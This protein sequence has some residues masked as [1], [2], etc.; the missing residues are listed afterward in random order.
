MFF[1]KKKLFTFSHQIENLSNLSD[2]QFTAEEYQWIAE[3]EVS[4]LCENK[5]QT[6]AY[7]IKGNFLKLESLSNLT[8][9]L[10][11]QNRH[12]TLISFGSGQCVLEYFLSIYLNQFLA[13][14]ATDFNKFF[15][16]KAQIFF[17]EISPHVFDFQKDSLSKLIEKTGVSFDIGVGFGS[18]YAMDDE[19]FIQFLRSCKANGLKEI[20]DFNPGY[21]C[22]TDILLNHF[23]IEKIKSN[24]LIRRTFGKK[25]KPLKGK[26]HGYARSRASL[27]R[28][29]S[30]S[31][32]QVDQELC[33]NAYNYIAILK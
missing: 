10:K 2:D 16:Q 17:P 7:Y 21:L 32:W 13:V 22:L 5:D 30:E 18:F 31:G 1:S 19:I 11:N 24:N 9:Y 23:S 14:F 26:F 3:K 4:H 8:R 27:R 12:K 29:Y 20:I 25:P 33:D 28:I 15:I 6:I